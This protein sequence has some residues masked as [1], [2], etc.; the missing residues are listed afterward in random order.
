ML[1]TAHCAFYLS[2]VAQLCLNLLTLMSGLN[3]FLFYIAK[4]QA[5]TMITSKRIWVKVKSC[6]AQTHEESLKSLKVTQT[7]S[8]SSPLLPFS[9]PSPSPVRLPLGP[10]GCPAG[11]RWTVSSWG[12]R[13]PW[14]LCLSKRRTGRRGQGEEEEEG[15]IRGRRIRRREDG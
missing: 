2:E 7:A 8:Y 4:W 15:S 13:F 3:V 11:G 12:S 5:Q 10:G 1:D 6:H 9:S 14:W